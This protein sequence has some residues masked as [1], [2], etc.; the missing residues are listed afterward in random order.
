MSDDMIKHIENYK[1]NT[2][3][4]KNNIEIEKIINAISV[5]LSFKKGN[6]TVAKISLKSVHSKFFFILRTSQQCFNILTHRFQQC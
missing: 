5:I 1:F 2:D 3:K 6:S 4:I